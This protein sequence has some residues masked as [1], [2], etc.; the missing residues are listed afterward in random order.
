MYAFFIALSSVAYAGIY[1][2]EAALNISTGKVYY[3][4][5]V[6]Y[7]N[8][9]KSC[10]IEPPIIEMFIERKITATVM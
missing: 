10:F 8:V 6:N 2:W 7:T 1:E 4:N 9:S 5:N 3:I